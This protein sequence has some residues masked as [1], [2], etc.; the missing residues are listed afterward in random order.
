MNI[1]AK[2]LG[3]FSPKF[4][5]FNQW[6]D[7]YEDILSSKDISKKTI[8]N[9]KSAL[10]HL[11]RAVGEESISRIRPYQIAQAAR[12]LHQTYPH[13]A[14]RMLSEAK[15]CFAEAVVMGWTD[16]NPAMAVKQLVAK[17]KRE[18]LSIEDWKQIYE[19]TKEHLP[20]WVSRMMVLSIISGQRRGDLQK[21]RFEDVHDGFLH[22][23]QQKTGTFLK[24][25]LELKLDI[26]DKT[27]AE[28]IED[29]KDYYP[30]PDYLLRK[31]TGEPL[32]ADSMSARFETAREKCLGKYTGTG[33]PP[34]LHE[35]RSLCERLFRDQGVDTQ[36]LLGHRQQKMT[37]SYNRERGL[38]Y[39]KYKELKLD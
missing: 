18:R 12:E 15:A 14:Q 30:N 16:T 17:V 37:D 39:G 7:K 6:A 5:T 32:S 36:T 10:K 27:L 35:C 3:H 21:M 33:F 11:R 23:R 9:H 29:C 34:S 38:Y 20:P 22:I 25:P 26:I 19:Y 31:S 4:K 1:L 2:T 28:A 13:S 8:D 24:I